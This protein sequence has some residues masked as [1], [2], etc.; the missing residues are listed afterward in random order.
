MPSSYEGSYAIPEGITSISG[1]AFEGCSGLTS[2]AIPNSVTTIG[3]GAFAG[4]SGLTSVTIP[5]SVTSIS[6]SAFEGCSGL[7]TIVVDESN[8]IYDSRENCNAI[9]ETASNR[10]VIG[11]SN[12]IIPNSITSIAYSA[13]SGCSGL[14]N[15]TIP[16]SV[17]S[18]GMGAFS[19]I[20]RAHV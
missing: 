14:N 16:N 10:L 11:C 15:I 20:G 3:D 1:S 19:E 17:T 18:I 2:I 6:P 5:N 12:T 7:V 8:V 4:C 9:I 13:F